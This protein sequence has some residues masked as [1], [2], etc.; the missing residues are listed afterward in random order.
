[1]GQYRPGLVVLAL[2]SVEFAMAT[3][4]AAA[5]ADL[6]EP[7]LEDCSRITANA[8]SLPLMLLDR[9]SGGGQQ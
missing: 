6:R 3:F 5:L 1:M 8:Q 9:K 4:L 7:L 2:R